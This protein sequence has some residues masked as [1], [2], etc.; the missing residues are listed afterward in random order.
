MV[1]W[2]PEMEAKSWQYRVRYRKIYSRQES[3]SCY[4]Q[5]QQRV[6]P[7]E[8]GKDYVVYD[9]EMY[10]SKNIEP[11]SPEDSSEDGRSRVP[12]SSRFSIRDEAGKVN[13]KAAEAVDISY[14][15]VFQYMFCQ[16]CI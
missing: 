7:K 11:S 16:I 2:K 5:Q 1:C 10:E 6:F 15:E 12:N 8:L 3:R 13:E 4:Y 9:I 14:D